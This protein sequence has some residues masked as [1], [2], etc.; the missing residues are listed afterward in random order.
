[1]GHEVKR[2][3][4]IVKKKW[5]VTRCHTGVSRLVESAIAASKV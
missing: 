1:M 5:D 4:R 2:G 3:E